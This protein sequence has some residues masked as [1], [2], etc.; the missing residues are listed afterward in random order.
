M[1]NLIALL[2]LAGLVLTIF[3]YE[4]DC[5]K[6]DHWIDLKSKHNETEEVIHD[7][8]LPFDESQRWK[9]ANQLIRLAVAILSILSVL[10]F[11][12]RQFYK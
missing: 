3:Q 1:D 9:Y 4:S 2:T 11:I 5:V 8:K 6:M 7:Q 10:L 12:V